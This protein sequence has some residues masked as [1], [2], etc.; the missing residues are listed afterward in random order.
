MD[1]VHDAHVVLLRRTWEVVVHRRRR[2]SDAYGC[3]LAP[4]RLA[5]NID[6]ITTEFG[7]QPHRISSKAM[8]RRAGPAY[9]PVLRAAAPREETMK[10]CFAQT[11][12]T[13]SQE[14]NQARLLSK[15]ATKRLHPPAPMTWMPNL[16]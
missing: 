5:S 15:S 9:M 16:T 2:V 3:V 4:L 11:V 10:L 1:C 13:T 8:R 6:A 12:E 7:S 14:R